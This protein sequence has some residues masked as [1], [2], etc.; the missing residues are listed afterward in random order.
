M[1]CV[2]CE[3]WR[4]ESEQD[5][6]KLS[7]QQ[8]KMLQEPDQEMW[9][10][11]LSYNPN[12]NNIISFIRI[13]ILLVL[14]LLVSLLQVVWWRHPAES[15]DRDQHCPDWWLQHPALQSAGESGG[16]SGPG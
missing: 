13:I 11:T 10:T 12:T 14:D 4:W 7:A 6:D 8:I 2:Q 9:K 1:E 16:E 3:L 5:Q 15:E